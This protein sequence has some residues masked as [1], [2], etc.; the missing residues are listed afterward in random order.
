[1]FADDIVG[2]DH[3]HLI[4]GDPI[5]G[6]DAVIEGNRGVLEVG[7]T[8]LGLTPL[9]ARGDRAV[10]MGAEYRGALGG[11]GVLQL[12]AVDQADRM[13]RSEVFELDQ[14]DLALRRLTELAAGA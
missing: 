8:A 2:L 6:P 14:V 10:L 7:V 11:L 9:A 12:I 13:L 1:M 3:R 5:V 4:G